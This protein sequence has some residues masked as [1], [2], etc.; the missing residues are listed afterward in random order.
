MLT[1]AKLSSTLETS[2]GEHLVREVP[3]WAIAAWGNVASFFPRR[4]Y[5]YLGARHPCTA[6]CIDIGWRETCTRAL[7]GPSIQLAWVATLGR[8]LS[9]DKHS[10]QNTSNAL[11]ERALN[12]THVKLVIDPQS[13]FAWCSKRIFFPQWAMLGKGQ[14][15]LYKIQYMSI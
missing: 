1:I 11:F 13:K 2:F 14:G 3:S 12:N 5:P 9:K 6:V 8:S 4:S 15:G 7:L 10:G